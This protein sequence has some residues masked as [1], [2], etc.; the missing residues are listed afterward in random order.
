MQVDKIGER[1]FVAVSGPL[2]QVDVH[3]VPH[4]RRQQ[5]GRFRE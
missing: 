5:S 4:P 3:R 1:N 2:D